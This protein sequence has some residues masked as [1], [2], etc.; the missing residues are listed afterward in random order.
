M[1]NSHN[2]AIMKE[3]TEEPNTNTNT[4]TTPVSKISSFMNSV[5][6]PSFLHKVAQTIFTT[7]HKVLETFGQAESVIDIDTQKKIDKLND[8]S[9]QYEN[10]STLAERLLNNFRALAES[11]KRMGNFLY[12]SGTKE[13]DDLSQP[14]HDSGVVHRALDKQTNEMV[15]SLRKLISVISTF[16]QAAVEDTI[17]NLD[18]YTQSRQQ[19]QGALAHL[20][21]LEEAHPVARISTDGAK[22]VVEE[23]K[24]AMD[25]AREDLLTKV[26]VL[27]QKRIQDLGVCLSEYMRAMGRYYVQNTNVF[28]NLKEEKDSQEDVESRRSQASAEFN[29]L[30]GNAQVSSNPTTQASSSEDSNT[31][32]TTTT[33][34]DMTVHIQDDVD[35]DEEIY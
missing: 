2:S 33:T 25:K 24:K 9:A 32:I 28:D 1:E 30:I 31:T 5:T 12:E 7:K 3:V 21:D 6:Y 18:R 23:S 4:N 27:N 29:S 34:T 17:L 15:T 26:V 35:V 13:L 11:Q 14:L 22:L 20:K 10:L 19:Y 8:I 16:R